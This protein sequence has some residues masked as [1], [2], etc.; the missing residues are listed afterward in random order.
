MSRFGPEVELDEPAFIHPSA[1]V[2]GKVRIAKDASLWPFV[3]I[4]AECGHVEIG[5][6]TNIQ[7]FT[8]IHVGFPEPAII[9]KHC[10][11]AHRCVVHG[12]TIGD[13]CLIGIGATIMDGAVIGANSIVAGGSFVTERTVV[14][15]N[16]I[17]MGVPAKA[18]KT[19]NN[20]IANR[21]NASI[22]VRNAKAYARGE[23]RAWHGAEFQAFAKTE[24]DRLK[25]DFEKENGA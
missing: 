4:R 11:V 25:R 19:R 24:M 20:W 10:S 8:M 6:G 2:H 5:E 18:T 1:L 17:V 22:Y 14:P 16:S 13:N 15:P 12:A 23:H 7:D 9:G 21:F 3:V